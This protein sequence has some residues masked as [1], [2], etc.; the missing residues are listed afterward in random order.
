MRFEFFELPVH[1]QRKR[2]ASN[3]RRA[4]RRMTKNISDDRCLL[5]LIY[6]LVNV[7]NR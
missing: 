5:D 1:K 6:K 4:P 2:L 3:I 7:F